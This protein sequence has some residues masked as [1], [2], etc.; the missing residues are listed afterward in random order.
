MDARAGCGLP[1]RSTRAG[2]VARAPRSECLVRGKN[3]WNRLSATQVHLACSVR[4]LSLGFARSQQMWREVE[5]ENAS[6]ANRAREVKLEA[7]A[8]RKKLDPSQVE[9]LSAR[10]E[11]IG[12]ARGI[13]VSSPGMHEAVE[14]LFL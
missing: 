10:A 5:R 9:T 7:A 14:E 6:D 8:L 4:R 11:V 3:R 13:A 1:P 2:F 12:P